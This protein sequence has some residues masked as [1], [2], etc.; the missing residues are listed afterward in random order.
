MDESILV[1]LGDGG[2]LDDGNVVVVNVGALVDVFLNL[3]V[4]FDGAADVS[5]AI[6]RRAQETYT[7]PKGCSLVRLTELGSILSLLWFRRDGYR[8]SVR[9]VVVEWQRGVLW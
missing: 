3:G 1:E 9:F 8:R 5:C 7:T 4:L 2:I 6:E